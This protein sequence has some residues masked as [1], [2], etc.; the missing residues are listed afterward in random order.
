MSQILDF[1]FMDCLMTD[2]WIDPLFFHEDF[3]D[4]PYNKNFEECGYES[5]NAIRNMGSTFIYLVGISTSIAF[6]PISVMVSK[7]IKK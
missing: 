3:E 6:H 2:S 4:E 7:K 5:R 1:V